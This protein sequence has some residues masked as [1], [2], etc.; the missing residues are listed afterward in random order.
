VGK[1]S[2]GEASESLGNSPELGGGGS[3]T[4]RRSLSSGGRDK[5]ERKKEATFRRV[6]EGVFSR[7]DDLSII[8]ID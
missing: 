8:Y 5:R 1:K 3:S 6:K 4:L 7:K 2:E